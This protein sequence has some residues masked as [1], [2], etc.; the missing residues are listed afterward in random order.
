MAKA[1]NEERSKGDVVEVVR[2]GRKEKSRG[3]G[4]KKRGKGDRQQGRF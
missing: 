2:R 4:Y 3:R 1:V